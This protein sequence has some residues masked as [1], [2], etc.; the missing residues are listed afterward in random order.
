[1]AEKD[2]ITLT[3]RWRK[4]ERR[5]LES[6]LVRWGT[7]VPLIFLSMPLLA[8]WGLPALGPFF[9]LLGVILISPDV[10]GYFSRWGGSLVW[11]HQEGEHV[12]LYSI[13]ESLVAK[14]KYVEAEEEYEK[15]IQEF[16]NEVK[17]H[18]DLINVAVHW[19]KNAELGE[20]L[21]KRGMTLLKDPAG[22]KLLTDAWSRIRSRLKSQEESAP[23]PIGT[24]KIEEA[25][26]RVE[27]ERK[28]RWR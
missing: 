12:P 1:M 18:V 9:I 14:G 10:A 5:K 2:N 27:E 4:E 26:K 25:K 17:P 23:A 21:Y 22:Q 28:Q 20:Q 3:D 16:P 6:R 13:A 19:M 7:G 15:I 11:R 24:E 8:I